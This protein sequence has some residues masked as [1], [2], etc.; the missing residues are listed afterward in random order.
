M[1]ANRPKSPSEYYKSIRPEY[2]SDSEITYK[3]ELPREHLAYELEKI[4]T[5]QKQ[6]EF[7]TLAR[8]LAEKF[9]APNLIPQVGPTGG[10][11]GK[12]DSET[13]PVSESISDKWYIPENGWEKDEKWAIAISAKKDWKNK[14]KSDIKN[15]VG[16]KRGYTRVYFITNQI[17]SS[18]KKKDAQDQFIKEFAID[19]VILDGE[20]ILEK[21]YNND[22]IDLVVDSLNM[23]DVYKRKSNKLGINDTYNIERLNELENNISNPN[24]YFE[25]DYQ[26]V[27]DAIESAIIS[28]KLSKPQEE[29]EGKFDRVFRLHDKVKNKKQLLRLHYQRAWTRLFYFDDYYGFIEDY[30][31]FKKYIS[32]QSSIAEAELYTILV[33]T[34]RTVPKLDK[35]T[36]EKSNIDFD[37]EVNVLINHLSGIANNKENKNSA[38]QA[39]LFIQLQWLQKCIIEEESAITYLRTIRELFESSIGF[40]DFP[41]ELF[42]RY[43]EVL[44]D[45]LLEEESYDDLIDSI[46]SITQKRSSEKSAGEIFLKRGFQKLNA[47]LHKES[48][49]YFGKALYKLAKEETQDELYYALMGLSSAYCSMGLLWISNNCI[50]SASEIAFR[51]WYEKGTINKRIVDTSKQ[52]AINEIIIGRISSFLIWFEIYQLTSR[53]IETTA[54]LDQIDSNDLLDLYLSVR[55]LNTDFSKHKLYSKLPDLLSDFDLW[56]SHSSALYILGHTDIILKDSPENIKTEDDLLSLYK[57]IANQPFGNDLINDTNLMSNDDIQLSSTILGC[58]FTVSLKQDKELLLAGETILAYFESFL[59]TSISSKKITDIVPHVEKIDIEL[60]R[61]KEEKLLS[62]TKKEHSNNYTVEIN[63]FNFQGESREQIGEKMLMFISHIIGDNF[64]LD[65]IKDFLKKIFENED[66]ISRLSF[67]F[68]HRNFTLKIHGDNEKYFFASWAENKKEYTSLRS[69][70]VSFI[71]SEKDN[72]SEKV[73]KTGRHDSIKI[74]TVINAQLWDEAKWLAFGVASQ[75]RFFGIIIGFE[76]G[77]LGKQIFQKW[78]NE[79]GKID[80][81]DAIKISIIKGVD[82]NNPNWYRVLIHPNIE[83]DSIKNG[84]HYL[85]YY[86]IHEMTPNSSENLDRIIALHKQTNGYFSLIP[87]EADKNTGKMK[88]YLDQIINKKDLIIL[89]AWEIGL[90]EP[91]SVVIRKGDQPIIPDGVINA[92]VLE[93]LKKKN[94]IITQ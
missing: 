55:L 27:E 15:I 45:Y 76:N 23:S 37:E 1:K 77:E 35:D 33:N 32:I 2:F 19:V 16:T 87:A 49:I 92:P 9:V 28:R 13:Y 81:T 91:E 48:V 93:V 68:E 88:P 56:S 89:N 69:K 67:V 82:K 62:F 57:S 11:D 18:K 41:F 38:L 50:V 80:K 84:T 78:I 17:P 70:R 21:T 72:N 29:V 6:D 39:K 85:T 71:D 90:N 24:R 51:S 66:I 34:L 43:I 7:E 30:L 61:N 12:T 73:T 31:E 60:V 14:A 20:W 10:G 3:V 4:T 40:I 83:E 79:Y 36:F 65:N 63:K 64:Y 8:R 5:N 26:L 47:E 86:R 74:N 94:E 44:G 54:E 22:L 52:L 25:H 53:Q 75:D 59:S 58:K 46:A 42:S